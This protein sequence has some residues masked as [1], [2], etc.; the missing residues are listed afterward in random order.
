[1]SKTG[2]R[3]VEHIKV[4]LSNEKRIKELEDMNLALTNENHE[5][6]V[7]LNKWIKMQEKGYTAVA[8]NN[9]MI[10]QAVQV[11]PY[12]TFT[13]TQEIDSVINTALYSRI[14]FYKLDNGKMCIDTAQ[15]IKY[16]TGGL[17]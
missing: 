3:V 17:L 6:E 5:L 14:P 16:N 8:I 4:K 1:M 12:S 11:L 2:Q 10:I 9:D 13:Y 7:K 15:K